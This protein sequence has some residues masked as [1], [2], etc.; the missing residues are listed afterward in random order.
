MTLDGHLVLSDWKINTGRI[1]ISVFGLSS[2]LQGSQSSVVRVFSSQLERGGQI[3]SDLLYKKV[4][5]SKGFYILSDMQYIH[6]VNF[7][8]QQQLT[9]RN[10]STNLVISQ[11]VSTKAYFLLRY[12]GTLIILINI[13]LTDN[14]KR[15]LLVVV[16]NPLS[17]NPNNT[18]PSPVSP[19]LSTSSSISPCLCLSSFILYVD[20]CGQ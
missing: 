5:A 19:A 6:F 9:E 11:S 7:S 16:K 12:K 17:H 20:L 4:S 2:V 18:A 10:S 13:S 3:V 8:T 1:I 14:R 15:L